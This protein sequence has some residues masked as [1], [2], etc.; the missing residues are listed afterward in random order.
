MDIFPAINIDNLAEELSVKKR[1]QQSGRLGEPKANA[2]S[3]DGFEV[4]IIGKMRLLLS[5]ARSTAEQ[6]L[7]Q[8]R[9]RV[10]EIDIT[11]VPNRIA[12]LKA[13]TDIELDRLLAESRGVLSQKRLRERLMYRTLNFFI[14]END[15]H[16][17]PQYPESFIL[18]WAF[19]AAIV[20][21]ESLAN[22]YFF[23]KGSDMGLI[24]GALQAFLISAVNVGVA[25]LAGELFR[26]IYHIDG[27]RRWLAYGSISIYA[28]V[29]LFFNLATGHYRAQLQLD[30]F[31]AITKAIPAMIDKPFPLDNFDSNVLVLIG[32]IA[33]LF[34]A[35]KSFLADDR[36]PGYGKVHRQYCEAGDV[37]E[38]EIKKLRHSINI[39]VDEK[40][41]EAVHLASRAQRDADEYPTLLDRME[42]LAADFER[43]AVNVEQGCHT[44]L[45]MYRSQNSTIRGGQNPNYFDDYPN[46][47]DGETLDLADVPKARN[48]IKSIDKVLEKIEQHSQSLPIE[49]KEI[50]KT[51]I[52]T[53][54][55]FIVEIEADAKETLSEGGNSD[56]MDLQIQN[57]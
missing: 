22:S 49:F 42:G 20:I 43:H 52:K 48:K 56:A 26:N 14:A 50:N 12:N 29:I 55:D 32:L 17:E 1:A 4:E 5:N 38:A 36:Y 25:L 57:N 6:A 19:I 18:H 23:A 28:V 53:I 40:R 30:P 10:N 27:H 13:D 35:G 21:A 54:D 46:L 3:P 11:N 37:Y 31:E 33:T 9:G 16:H 47:T 41:V 34:A 8:L 44:L 45:K 24:G 39:I 51:A 15:I 2:M 7:M